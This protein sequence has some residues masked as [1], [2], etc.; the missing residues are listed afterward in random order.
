M[1][2]VHW[3]EVAFW[4]FLRTDSTD[5]LDC[6][7]ILLSLSVF[8]LTFFSFFPLFLFLVPYIRLSWLII[9]FSAHIELASRIASC[10]VDVLNIFI[11]RDLRLAMPGYVNLS[12]SKRRSRWNRCRIIS[13]QIQ[14]PTNNKGLIYDGGLS[15]DT[16]GWA[17]GKH[18]ACKIIEWWGVGA[19]ICLERGADCLHYRPADATAIPKPHHFLSRLNPDWFY[20]SGTGLPRL[21]W[22]SGRQTGVWLGREL[23]IGPFCV[24][25]PDPTHQLTDPANPTQPTTSGK[26][27]TQPDATNKFNCSVQPNLI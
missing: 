21:S 12:H 16:I 11:F 10:D 1:H 24:T 19:V 2:A 27:W 8:T 18:L 17:S 4:F 5:S 14:H 7:P 25:R 13:R 9:S 22:K 23:S 6:L 26:I 3:W 15:P 20:L